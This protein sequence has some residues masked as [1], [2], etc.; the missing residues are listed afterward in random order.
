MTISLEA[1]VAQAPL[2]GEQYEPS[3]KIREG[4]ITSPTITGFE[5][6]VAAIFDADLNVVALRRLLADDDAQ[7]SVR[8]KRSDR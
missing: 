6:P 7:R 3:P 2:R 4:N 1:A 8:S 5:I